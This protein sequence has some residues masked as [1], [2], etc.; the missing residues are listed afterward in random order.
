MVFC[1][2]LLRRENLR[3]RFSHRKVLLNWQTVCV[4]ICCEAGYVKIWTV[5]TG[6]DLLLD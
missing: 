3:W 6:A 5:M 2:N 1:S 4:F